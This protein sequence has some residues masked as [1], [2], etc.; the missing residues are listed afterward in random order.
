MQAWGLALDKSHDIPGTQVRKLHRSV[1]ELM[2]EESMDERHIMDDGG[3]S[4]HAFV[5]QV[6]LELLHGLLDR[7]RRSAGWDLL[8]GDHALTA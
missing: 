2:R 3:T 6:A 8:R 4:Q 5:A 7:G 1:A